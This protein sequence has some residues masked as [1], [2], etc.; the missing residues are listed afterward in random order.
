M[1]AEERVL[2]LSLRPKFAELLLGGSKTVELR[3][4]APAIPP[5]APVLLYAASPI[6]A[7]VGICAVDCVSVASREQIWRTYGRSTGLS[8]AD[9]RTY[10]DG[11]SSAVA[12]T[13]RDLRPLRAPIPLADLRE[14]DSGFR[15]PQSFRYLDVAQVN[16][17]G[18]HQ[19]WRGGAWPKRARKIIQP[20]ALAGVLRQPVSPAPAQ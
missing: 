15:P 1:R 4:V 14:R 9:F 19:E 16:A 8:R 6:K 12:I 3:R 13:L 10:F 2:F 17:L 5:G 11:A 18:L 20:S 7:L